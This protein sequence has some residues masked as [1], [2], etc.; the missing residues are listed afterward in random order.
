MCQL[1]THLVYFWMPIS[2]GIESGRMIMK[3]MRKSAKRWSVYQWYGISPSVFPVTVSYRD[4]HTE[5]HKQEG[6]YIFVS[7]SC[8]CI[9]ICLL[10]L[11]TYG[12]TE[13]TH[14]HT[15]YVYPVD[16]AQP[17]KRPQRSWRGWKQSRFHTDGRSSVHTPLAPHHDMCSA[18]WLKRHSQ[19]WPTHLS[20]ILETPEKGRKMLNYFKPAAFTLALVV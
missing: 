8:V 13:H 17:P 10:Q 4:R 18:D 1:S 20:E 7:L 19:V 15:T 9:N 6:K 11:L 2:L 14:T 5:T 12:S 3:H 16:P